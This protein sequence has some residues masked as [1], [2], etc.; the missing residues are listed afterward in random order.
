MLYK[1]MYDWSLFH[2][3]IAHKSLY[4][5]GAGASL[6]EINPS[7]DKIRKEI[8]KNGIFDASRQPTSL[9]KERLLPPLS[10]FTTLDSSIPQNELDAHTPTNLIEILFAQMITV[11][12]VSR[13]AQYEVFDHFSSSILFNFNNDNLADAV[14]H[15]H[16][17]LYPH[18]RVNFGLAHSPILNL[19]IEMLAIPDS[20]T[21]AF[22][23]HRPLPEPSNITSQEPYLT[24]KSNFESSQSVIIIGYSF[25][26]QTATGSIDDAES[27]EMIVDLLRWRPKRVLIIDPNP[28]R[29]YFRIESAVRR[30][31]VSILRCKW[32]VLAAFILSGA[33]GRAYKQMRRNDWQEITSLYQKFEDVKHTEVTT[34]P[35]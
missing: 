11:P 25:G 4:I 7:A 26:Y 23:Y 35:V 17:C 19:A 9:L 18:R 12:G 27:F 30:N 22:G 2:F 5:L 15:R 6:P 1:A 33:F 16:L 10:P 28:E 34:T 3:A 31:T 32:N 20:I 21:D 29:L 8:W 13:V 14:H 24:L